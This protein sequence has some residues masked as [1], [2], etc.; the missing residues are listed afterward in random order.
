[1]NEA[2]D[3]ASQF[4]ASGVVYISQ[5]RSGRQVP[6][7][8][9]GGGI[10]TTI[11]LVL[12]VNGQTASSAEIVTG[13]IKDA[14]RATIVGETTYGTGT[15]VGTYPLADGSAVT[16]GTERWLTPKGHAIWREGLT[17]DQT[18][19]L[20]QGVNFLVPDDFSTLGSGP[21]VGWSQRQ[22]QLELQ[23]APDWRE[24][25]YRSSWFAVAVG[26]PSGGRGSSPGPYPAAALPFARPV[27]AGSTG[28]GCPACPSS[29]PTP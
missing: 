12:L 25:R 13:A 20:A 24:C 14:G 8:V 16:I 23:L 17:P 5:D 22:L 6:H 28:S 3:V 2:I 1:M 18:V 7:E 4:L 19:A 29:A 26:R 9:A 11:P 27:V 10:A 21:A 15:V